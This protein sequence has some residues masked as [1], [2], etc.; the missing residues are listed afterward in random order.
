MFFNFALV[1]L[2]R[3]MP[4]V[5]VPVTFISEKPMS[6]FW[7]EMS[8]ASTRRE[9]FVRREPQIFAVLIGPA[10]RLR[11]RYRQRISK[12]NVMRRHARLAREIIAVVMFEYAFEARRGTCEFRD[13]EFGVGDARESGVERFVL[14]DAAAGNEPCAACGPIAAMTEQ[15]ASVCI[16]N[17]Q[18]DRNERRQTNNIEEVDFRQHA[19]S[20]A[21]SLLPR[22]FPWRKQC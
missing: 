12:H 13:A 2:A 11:T 5:Q 6:G 15:N 9:Q 14:E 3:V 21:S 19:G 1:M 20:R 17:E 4:F 7:G 8:R 22:R 10:D 16:A 18:I